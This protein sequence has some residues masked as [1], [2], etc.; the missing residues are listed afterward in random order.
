MPS[1]EPGPQAAPCPREDR[2]RRTNAVRS[3]SLRS[4]SASRRGRTGWRV[5]AITRKTGIVGRR[6][7]DVSFGGQR[8]KDYRVRGISCSGGTAAGLGGQQIQRE[9][10]YTKR[11]RGGAGDSLHDRRHGRQLGLSEYHLR[12]VPLA[13]PRCDR[14]LSEGI[15]RAFPRQCRVRPVEYQPRQRGVAKTWRDAEPAILRPVR[16][17]VPAGRRPRSTE[18]PRLCCLAGDGEP[19]PIRRLRQEEVIGLNP[20][21]LKARPGESPRGAN[22]VP[23]ALGPGDG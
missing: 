18:L 23:P 16:A 19:R 5:L 1:T 12:R 2:G 13:Q 20:S 15:D 8:E 11:H 14:G 4:A 7:D 9:L 6:G 22:Q 3:L 10:L 17:Y 21:C